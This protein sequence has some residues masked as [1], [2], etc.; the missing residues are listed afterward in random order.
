MTVKRKIMLLVG[1]VALVAGAI[2][3]LF[4]NQP[5]PSEAHTVS[6]LERALLPAVTAPPPDPP[7]PKARFSRTIWT[8]TTLATMLPALD[9]CRG[10]VSADLG[11]GEPVYV[12]EHDYCG[13]SAWMWKLGKKD[14][15]ALDGAGVDAGTYVV[16]ELKYFPRKAGAD[17]SDLPPGD[18][19]LQTCVSKTQMVFIALEKHEVIG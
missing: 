13:G 14:L 15:V 16:T 9:A 4:V 18:V 10:P 1:V 2:V 5:A 7:K 17:P 12:A 19:V 3:V 11:A 6:Q 8:E